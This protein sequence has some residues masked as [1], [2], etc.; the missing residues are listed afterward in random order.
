MENTS[1]P[2]DYPGHGYPMHWP[3]L[4]KV[5][6][7]QVPQS[8][9]ERTNFGGSMHFPI[10]HASPKAHTHFGDSEASQHTNKTRSK[11]AFILTVEFFTGICV[12]MAHL[13]FL[14]KS[15]LLIGYEIQE[16][17]YEQYSKHQY[18]Y[19]IHPD[20]CHTVT[21][22]QYSKNKNNKITLIV[23]LKER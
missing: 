9:F 5:S 10:T 15:S 16:E 18:K 14:Y 6:G 17:L 8:S 23:C 13:R 1:V 4:Q 11:N 2:F 20:S 21:D 3:L 12:G 7:G 19:I 22:S